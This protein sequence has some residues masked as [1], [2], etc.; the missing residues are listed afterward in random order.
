MNQASCFSIERGR[1]NLETFCENFSNNVFLDPF[2]QLGTYTLERMSGTQRT[3]L[4]R[5]I[6][7]VVLSSKGK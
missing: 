7:I 1:F 3:S 2:P 4:G 5:M 6:V